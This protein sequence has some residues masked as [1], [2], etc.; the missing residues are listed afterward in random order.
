MPIDSQFIRPLARFYEQA[1][2]VLPEVSL[3]HGDAMPEPHRSLLVHQRDMTTTLEK[4][5]GGRCHLR[6]LQRDGDDD[7]YNRLVVLQLED[8][9][10][11][12]FGA[13]TIFLPA[14][15]TEAQATIRE[16][17]KPLGS[18]LHQEKVGHYSRPRAFFQVPC[19]ELIQRE[20]CLTDPKVLYGRCNQLFDEG[21]TLLAEIV[22]ILPPV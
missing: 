15:S 3:V 9:K 12:E 13:I 21:G 5:H 20:L 14:F 19:D 1:E 8:G 16:E 11:I 17:R 6:V 2:M 18:I 10:P 4:F 7:S 22:E